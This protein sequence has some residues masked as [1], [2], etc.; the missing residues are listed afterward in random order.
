MLSCG[1]R[2]GCRRR[3]TICAARSANAAYAA[4]LCSRPAQSR[5]NPPPP[6]AHSSNPPGFV[7]LIPRQWTPLPAL[8]GKRISS[9]QVANEELNTWKPQLRMVSGLLQHFPR[10]DLHTHTSQGIA[11]G[12]HCSQ[13]AF[14]RRGLVQ[15]PVASIRSLDCLVD[16]IPIFVS[17]S[18]FGLE[19]KCHC[20]GTAYCAP[21]NDKPHYAHEAP[22]VGCRLGRK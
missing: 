7:L 21:Q 6:S 18:V 22:L 10:T 2:V 1:F 17:L 13:S 9:T 14:H 20:G 4:K 8:T 11:P 12:S 16:L 3:L 15:H 19:K 5:R